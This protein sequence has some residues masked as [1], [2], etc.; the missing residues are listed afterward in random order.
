MHNAADRSGEYIGL[1]EEIASAVQSSLE[2]YAKYYDFI[3]GLDVYYIT[4]LLNPRYKG[5]LLIQELGLDG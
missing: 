5:R 4:L 2:L 1:N 3:D